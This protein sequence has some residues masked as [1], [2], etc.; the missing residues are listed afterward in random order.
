MRYFATWETGRLREAEVTSFDAG[1]AAGC[2]TAKC[3]RG[4]HAAFARALD[5][6]VT[7]M[8]VRIEKLHKV[9]HAKG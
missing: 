6:A 9:V 7:Y 8:Q 3:R 4:A 2:H 1:L 5:E